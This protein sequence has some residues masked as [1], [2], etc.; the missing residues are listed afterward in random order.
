M[1]R[2]WERGSSNLLENVVHRG[3]GFL[4]RRGEQ[5]YSQLAACFS[6]FRVV[7]VWFLTDCWLFDVD[8]IRCHCTEGGRGA[9]A[10]R[11]RRREA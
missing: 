6:L 3:V 8:N 1:G 9:E 5:L 10:G 11:G 7:A 4:E 2:G